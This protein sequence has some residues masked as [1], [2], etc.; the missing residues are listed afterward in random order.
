[1]ANDFG[2]EPDQV[3]VPKDRSADAITVTHVDEVAIASNDALACVEAHRQTLG[4][5]GWHSDEIERQIEYRGQGSSARKTAW[6]TDLAGLSLQVLQPISG[7]DILTAFLKD[8]GP[9]V[10]YLGA[11]VEDLDSAVRTLE[12]EGM[13]LLQSEPSEDGRAAYMWH[14]DLAVIW[15]FRTP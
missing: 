14:P 10:C 6:S 12:T 3:G 13:E 4:I 11:S 7:T 8:R 1:M 9:G 15:R 2:V 5:E